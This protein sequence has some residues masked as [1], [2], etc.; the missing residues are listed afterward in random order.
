[1]PNSARSIHFHLE[2]RKILGQEHRTRL[3][4]KNALSSF[5]FR[6]RHLTGTCTKRTSYATSQDSEAL[7]AL[8]SQ[9]NPSWF[10]KP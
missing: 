7:N 3:L 5:D 9:H 1:L 8:L 2:Q 10:G 6:F 4:E